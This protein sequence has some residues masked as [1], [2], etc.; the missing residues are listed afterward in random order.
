MRRA[1]SKI[2]WDDSLGGNTEH[3]AKHGLTKKEVE[4][5]LHDRNSKWAWSRSSDRP[6]YLGKTASGKQLA[7]VVENYGGNPR[8]LYPITAYE[9]TPPRD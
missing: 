8:T 1:R 5:V 7:V 9:I 4:D 2:L 3:I 6:I